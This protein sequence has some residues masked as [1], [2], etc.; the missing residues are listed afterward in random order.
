MRTKDEILEGIIKEEEE[1][2]K[3]EGYRDARKHA[4]LEMLIDIRDILGNYF[5]GLKKVVSVKSG[6]DV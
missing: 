1:A 6:I 3:Y 5:A 2:S 4:E